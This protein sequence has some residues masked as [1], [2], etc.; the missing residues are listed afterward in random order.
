ML[1]YF[2]MK[3]EINKFPLQLSFNFEAS[4]EPSQESTMELFCENN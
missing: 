2:H 4:W 3:N 1:L